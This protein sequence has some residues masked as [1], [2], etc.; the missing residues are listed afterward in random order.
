M[1]RITF[2][3]AEFKVGGGGERVAANLANHFDSTGQYEVRIVS[4]TSLESSPQYSLNSGVELVSLGFPWPEG[5]VFR[6]LYGK[7]KAF[8]R[9]AS[10]PDLKESD[11]VLGIGTYPSVALGLF[12][13][14]SPFSIGCEHL[15]FTACPWFWSMLRR[16]SYPG[17]DAVV[18]LTDVDRVR[19]AR[20]C[21]NAYSIPNSRSFHPDSVKP[22]TNKRLLC[23]ARLT[24]QKGVDMLLDVYALV[25][26]ARPEWSLKI[27]GSGPDSEKINRKVQEL[28]IGSSTQ[29]I[30][31]CEN[32]ED[33]YQQA[34]IY[35]L[36]SRWE[37]FPM[38][39][40]EAQ[41]CGLPVVAFNC[42]TGPAEIISD[43]ESG[44]LVPTFDTNQMADRIIELIDHPERRHKFS[45]QAR[46][47]SDRFSPELINMKWDRLVQSLLEK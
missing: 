38:V 46:N 14:S 13:S 12:R 15:A 43:G 31:V 35:V 6:R 33:E 39:L 44:Y 28:G 24:R 36:T 25:N 30:D 8:R 20:F 2:L 19:L 5:P 47:N 22:S 23:V 18:A 27:I 17:L 16:L 9:I 37:G 42:E 34:A 10:S 7:L 45:I 29:I 41:A 40:L 4:I 1:K 26:R 32:M 21:T 3:V 11:I